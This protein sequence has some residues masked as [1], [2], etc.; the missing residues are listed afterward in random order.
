MTS[1][2]LLLAMALVSLVA[3]G[4]A[5]AEF[6]DGN[7]LFDFCKEEGRVPIADVLVQE[8]AAGSL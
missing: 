5:S 6:I 7:K 1:R 8:P 4:K 3:G 2:A